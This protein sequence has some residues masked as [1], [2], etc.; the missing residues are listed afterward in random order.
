[1]DGLDRLGFP[2]RAQDRPSPR[3]TPSQH[4]WILCCTY[5]SSWHVAHIHRIFRALNCGNLLI[6]FYFFTICKVDILMSYWS[7]HMS[8]TS[9]TICVFHK[10]GI[11]HLVHVNIFFYPTLPLASMHFTCV[12]TLYVQIGEYL[13]GPLHPILICFDLI[14]ELFH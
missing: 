7:Y 11:N 2:K 14:V 12:R 8:I 3:F 13:L 4:L 5:S 9:K 1:M 6:A 10:H